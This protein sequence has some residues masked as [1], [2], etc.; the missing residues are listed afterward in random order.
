MGPEGKDKHVCYI[1]HGGKP[2]AQ[3]ESIADTGELEITLTDDR[4]AGPLIMGAIEPL[5]FEMKIGLPKEWRCTN[6]KRFIKLLMSYGG[7]RNAAVRMASAVPAMKGQRSYQQLLFQTL[8][9][10]ADYCLNGKEE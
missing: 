10:Y 3:F 5:A 9:L 7:S 1:M 8:A 6:R 2:V 4:D